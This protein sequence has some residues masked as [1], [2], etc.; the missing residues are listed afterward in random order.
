MYRKNFQSIG[1]NNC[2]SSSIW[3]EDV[4]CMSDYDEKQNEEFAIN[5]SNI[6]FNC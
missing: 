5:S 1:I 6:C 4:R 3:R 2:S